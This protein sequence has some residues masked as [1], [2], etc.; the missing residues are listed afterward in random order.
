MIVEVLELVADAARVDVLQVGKRVRD[1]AVGVD[2][3]HDERRGQLGQFL[4]RGAEERRRELRVTGR[5]AAQRV[6]TRELMAVIPES[7]NQ[8]GGSRDDRQ[9]PTQVIGRLRTRRRRKRSGL[10]G[11]GSVVVELVGDEQPFGDRPLALRLEERAPL[12]GDP[13]GVTR[14][15][16]E[17][18]LSVGGIQTVEEWIVH[19]IRDI[20][21]RTGR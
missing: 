7:L 15:F 2:F 20:Q 4:H 5:L 17:H 12:R 9:G 18:R 14:V 8:C 11:S 19:R 3:V 16:F 21:C 10:E 13:F 6:D 1:R